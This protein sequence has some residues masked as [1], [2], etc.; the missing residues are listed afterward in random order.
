MEVAFKKSFLKDL[1]THSGQKIKKLVKS[2]IL[3]LENAHELSEVSNIIK[4]KNYDTAFRM[5]IGKYRL[6]FYYSD[7]VIDLAR[8]VKREDIY[9][10]F[11]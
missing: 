2:K 11:P 3:E 7:G 5:R 6:G 10:V 1:K 8:F 4:M 9:D